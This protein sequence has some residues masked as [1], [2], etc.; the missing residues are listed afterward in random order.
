MKS[1]R[2]PRER[3]QVGRRRAG[4]GKKWI[5]RANALARRDDAALEAPK[6]GKGQEDEARSARKG[7]ESIVPAQE[8]L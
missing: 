3:S 1:P 4:S 7:S 6:E 2:A 5:E 8:L